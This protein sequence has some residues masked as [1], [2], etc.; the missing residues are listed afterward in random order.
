M[1]NAFGIFA[2]VGALMCAVPPTA[3]AALILAVD[4]NGSQ[5][6]A[7]DNSAAGTCF[8]GTQLADLDPTVGVLSLG[9]AV[10]GGVQVEGSFHSQDTDGGNYLTSSSLAI[11]NLLATAATIQ[12]SVG[13]TDYIGP[14]SYAQAT[15]SG[16]WVNSAGSS[17]TYTYYNSVLNAQ[18]GQTATDRE[19]ALLATFTDISAGGPLDSF[20]FDSGPIPFGDPA[21]FSMTL[22]FDLTLLGGDRLDSR[23]QALFKDQVVAEVPE[24]L[25]LLLMGAGL[26]GGVLRR[27]A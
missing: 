23:G 15:G 19:G 24:P 13:A 2:L 1:R 4:V 11:I 18:G 14:T 6:C 21:L 7:V 27:K 26:L 3:D 8:F 5:A 22:G 10:I 12:A 17:T 20:A 9:T 25:S 16:T